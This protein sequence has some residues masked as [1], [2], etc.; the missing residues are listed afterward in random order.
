MQRVTAVVPGGHHVAA[1]T[2]PLSAPS[3]WRRVT[4]PGSRRR[5]LAVALVTAC[6]M[7]AAGALGAARLQRFMAITLPAVAPIDVYAI[8][9]DATPITI[10]FAAEGQTILWT[11]TADDVRRGVT[12]W[13][14]LRLADWNEIAEPLRHEA[15]D[16]MLARY[17][18]VLMSPTRWD[19]MN[20]ED[21]DAVPQPM[22]TVAFRQMVAY[23]SGFYQVG[24]RYGLPPGR[25]SDTLAAIVMSESWFNHRGLHVN[26]D[27][28]HD[29]GLAGASEFARDRLRQL[30]ADGVVDAAFTDE[31]Y[32]DPWKAT[33]FVAIWMSLLLDE[34]AGDLDLAVRAYNRGLASANDDRGTLYLTMVHQR[35]TRFI[36]N[37]QGPPAWDYLWHKSRELESREW[38]WTARRLTVWP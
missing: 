22:R 10:P 32:W 12:L 24:A 17:Q 28:T 33:R 11:T 5:S 4:I 23:W 13:R 21:W 15:L 6:A 14:R 30:Q 20:A 34:T 31:E 26:R 35:L 1:T 2:A 25:V 3:P 18:G 38:P 19:A 27:G 37:Q 8:W 36:L 16:N 29:I 9:L 7:I